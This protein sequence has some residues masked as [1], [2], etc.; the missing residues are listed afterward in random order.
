MKIPL[1]RPHDTGQARWASFEY[2]PWLLHQ[3]SVKSVH[4]AFPSPPYLLSRQ[5][6]SS[7]QPLENNIQT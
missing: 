5:L 2:W 7:W 6:G 4:L 3:S 1:Q